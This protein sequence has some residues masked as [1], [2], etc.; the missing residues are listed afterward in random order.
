MLLAGHKPQTPR[1]TSIPYSID[2]GMDVGNLK[3]RGWISTVDSCMKCRVIN[4]G[5]RLGGLPC[6]AD[7]LPTLMCRELWGSSV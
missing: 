1:P 3:V 7:R 5:Y 2:P 4:S 6:V